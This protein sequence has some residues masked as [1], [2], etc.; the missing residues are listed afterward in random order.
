MCCGAKETFIIAVGTEIQRIVLIVI[1][2]AEICSY[3]TSQKR[4]QHLSMTN[5][6]LALYSINL[7]WKK[8]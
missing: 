4:F 2:P 6:F 3:A 5:P 1:D 7:A 8:G